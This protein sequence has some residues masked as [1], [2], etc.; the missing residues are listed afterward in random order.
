[1]KLVKYIY[2]VGILL[3]FLACHSKVQ[4][5]P[6]ASPEQAQPKPKFVTLGNENFVNNYLKLVENKRVGLITNPRGVTR[7]LEYTSDVFFNHP[8]INLVALFGPEH[9]IRGKRYN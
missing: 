4:I 2:I 3:L 7:N 8:K 9:G 6:P 1:M 5:K